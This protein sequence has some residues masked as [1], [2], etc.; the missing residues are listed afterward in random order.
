M[1]VA[2]MPGDAREMQR[3]SAADFQQWFRR[4]DDLNQPPVFQH[5]RVATTQPSRGRQ[6][7]QKGSPF[8][9][10]HRYT[11]TMTVVVIEHDTIGRL[12]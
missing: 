9:S 5:Q 8:G 2:Q 12:A 6:I 1:P 7:K 10:L 11:A 4:G 3:I